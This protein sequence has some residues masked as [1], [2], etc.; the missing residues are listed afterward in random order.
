M[1]AACRI[2]SSD[3]L[4]VKGSPVKRALAAAL[5]LLCVS[6]ASA[7]ADPV[8]TVTGQTA[9]KQLRK[10]LPYTWTGTTAKAYLTFMKIKPAAS[11]A[12]YSRDLFPHWRDADTWG[13]PEAPNDACNAALYRYG[14]NV[15]M[16]STCTKLIGT[17][18]DP[19]GS[20]SQIF[21]S[22]SD[23]DGDHMVPLAA[24]WRKGAGAWDVTKRTQFANDPLNVV[25]A[26]D[27]MN[28]SKGDSDPSQWKPQNKASWCLYGVRWIAV[29]KKY[30]LPLN[31]QAEKDALKTMLATC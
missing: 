12:G 28:S 7:T 21:D 22:T 24:A 30:G 4:R 11:M 19:Y 9:A 18:I 8:G 27:R 10:G 13:W 14:R 3:H 29:S 20:P 6:A 15:Q 1:N 25:I 26:W 2:S 16:S 17:W 31:S 5:A 23:M